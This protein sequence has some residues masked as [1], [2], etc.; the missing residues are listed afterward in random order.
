MLGCFSISF[1]AA[2][3][4]TYKLTDVYA[5]SMQ[6][7]LKSNDI[8]DAQSLIQGG[9]AYGYKDYTDN[10]N[11][12][13]VMKSYD[14]L[15]KTVDKLNLDVSYFIEGRLRTKEIYE[16]VPFDIKVGAVNENMYEQPIKFK[17]LNEHSFEV[18]YKRGE[19]DQTIKGFFGK[20]TLSP[21]FQIEVTKTAAIE[22]GTVEQL[23]QVEY[24]VKF[25]NRAYQVMRY[26]NALNVEVPEYTGIL[27]VTVEDIIPQRAVAFLDTL[28]RVYIEN[29]LASK[30]EVNSRTL[31]YIERQLEEL[32]SMMTTI[33]DKLQ[34]YKL[35]QSI[36]DLS[37]EQEN[38]FNQLVDLQSQEKKFDMQLSA[39]SA[40]QKYIIEDKD[41]EQMPPTLFGTGNDAFLQNSVTDLYNAQMARNIQLFTSTKK[42]PPI[43]EINQKIARMKKDLLVYVDNSQ[44][45][46]GDQRI[47]LLRQIS[48]TEGIIGSIPIKQ[49]EVLNIERNLEVNQK[50]YSFLLE[51][52]AENTISRAGIVPESK[53]IES[54]RSVGI[55]K[56]NKSRIVYSFLGVGFIISVILVFIRTT[57]YE[58]IESIDFLK[59][60]TTYPI[61]GEVIFQK[62]ASN[63]SPIVVD[64]DPRSIITESFRTI[65]TNLQF[66]TT[67][68][69]P[70]VFLFTSNNPGEGKTFCSVNLGALLAKG[71][72]KV[73]LMEFDL[74]QPR[75]HQ[76][77]SL[78]SEIGLTT[79][80]IGK[81]KP[82]DCV[83]NSSVENLDVILSGP[84]P[85]NASEL[86]LHQEI[87]D[88]FDFAKANYD[89]ILIDTPPIGLITDALV[90]MRFADVTMFVINTKYAYRESLA[91]AHEAAANKGNS[92]FSFILNGVKRSQSKYYY[93]RYGYGY[94]YGGKSA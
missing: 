75:V 62:D 92:N 61:L 51:K 30:L 21:D 28:G 91:N 26:Q 14:L 55:V 12:I 20:S 84:S 18:R 81:A 78:S 39:L 68:D 44:K 35:S 24:M 4:Y 90:L 13:R 53:V 15:K 47:Q 27:Q 10:Y 65:R 3:F 58:T 7:L 16:A 63:T 74:H 25:H 42:G 41:P 36:L 23:S 17:I 40:L 59:Q 77:L 54:A 29:S 31:T 73:L 11:A 5:A 93:K 80:L 46:I 50:M 94:G 87:N 6:I 64:S 32:T 72:K 1:V 82:E 2:Y 43:D 45:V 56:P 85:P 22:K 48:R 79:I 52:K 89:Y 19:S 76:A 66:L 57:F 37:R 88:L 34:N 9:G 33:E 71:G 60:K 83:I 69:G 70:K 86:V 67:G 8:Y 38:A 49:R